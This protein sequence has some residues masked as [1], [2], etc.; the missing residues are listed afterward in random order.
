MAILNGTQEAGVG[1]G[2]VFTSFDRARWDAI[3]GSRACFG[4]GPAPIPW[5]EPEWMPEDTE[6]NLLIPLNE[7]IKAGR[8]GGMKYAF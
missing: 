8:W 6:Q 3:F 4:Q 1:S 2:W 5:T 7:T